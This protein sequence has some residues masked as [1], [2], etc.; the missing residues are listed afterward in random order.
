VQ[1][2]SLAAGAVLVFL[3]TRLEQVFSRIA[4]FRYARYALRCVTF[5]FVATAMLPPGP[6]ISGWVRSPQLAWSLL[7]DPS[8]LA[9][10]VAI[11][12]FMQ[13]LSMRPSPRRRWH[14]LLATAKLRSPVD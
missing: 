12:L 1:V 3:C 13:W 5:G 11:A 4:V 7:R 14:L 2:F 8:S 10:V 6:G 9:V